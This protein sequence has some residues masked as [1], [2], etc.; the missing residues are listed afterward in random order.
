MLDQTLSHHDFMNTT[1]HAIRRACLQTRRALSPLTQHAASQRVCEQILALDVYQHATHVAFY[2]AIQGEIDLTFLWRHASQT[3]KSCYMPKLENNHMLSFL[4]STPDTPTRIN[5]FHLK[6]PDVD[7]TQARPLHAIDLL[8]LPLVAFDDHGTR[9]GRGAGYYD[10]TLANQQPACLLGVAYAFQHQ[11]FIQ[12]DPWDIPLTG[13]VT[14]LEVHWFN[15]M[16]PHP[17]LPFA[18]E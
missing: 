12:S 15:L 14:E 5:H 2:D 10:R 16:H 17:S 1:K 6:E 3:G 9:L 18:L 7:Q 11:R 4:P 13:I 8:L